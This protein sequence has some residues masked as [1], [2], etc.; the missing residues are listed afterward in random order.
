MLII[1]F[2]VANIFASL[3]LML[4]MIGSIAAQKIKMDIATILS[5]MISYVFIAICV[6]LSIM[7]PWVFLLY[8]VS[9]TGTMLFW[10]RP[11]KEEFLFASILTIACFFF[12]SEMIAL[13]IFNM[14]FVKPMDENEG[15]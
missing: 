1:S 7:H 10:I 3:I 12:W 14:L 4:T 13:M 5:I 9:I 15:D 8:A 6:G 11:A 2:V